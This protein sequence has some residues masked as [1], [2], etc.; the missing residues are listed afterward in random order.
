VGVFGGGCQATSQNYV[1]S[2]LPTGWEDAQ[3]EEPSTHLLLPGE[4]VTFHFPDGTHHTARIWEDGFITLPLVGSVKAEGKTLHELG[5]EVHDLYVP[6]FYK[7]WWM[8][9]TL[10][11]RVY[12]VGGQVKS[13]GRQLYIGATTVTKAIQSA[14]DFTNFAAKKRVK[15]TRADGQG[16][17]VN[18]IKA[19]KEPALDLPVYP[20]DKIAVPQRTFWDSFW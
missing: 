3:L 6:R 18:C 20:G 11:Q 4:E 15:L 1:F 2:P 19:A 5:K 8:T 16:I 7:H 12:H 9:G 13:P 17:E 14:G 10:D